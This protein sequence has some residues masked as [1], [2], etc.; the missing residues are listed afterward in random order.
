MSNIWVCGDC[1]SVNP[2]RSGRCYKC[3]APRPP[4]GQEMTAAVATAFEAEPEAPRV[5]KMLDPQRIAAAGFGQPAAPVE[6]TRPEVSKSA[7]AA[8]N[9][10]ARLSTLPA[11]I[12]GIALLIVILGV[13]LVLMRS[14][15][16]STEAILRG[17]VSDP[18][19]DFVGPLG[20][21]YP[22]FGVIAVAG[23]AFWAYRVMTNVPLLGGG[24][25]RFTPAQ[26]LLE[27]VIP[28]WNVLRT[29]GVYREIQTRLSED[30]DAS[31]LLI[32]AWVL[33]NIAA[34]AIVRPIGSTIAGFADSVESALTIITVVNYLSIGLQ[35]L[36]IL[37]IA[38]LVF[39]IEGQQRDRAR[40]LLAGAAAPAQP[41]ADKPTEAAHSAVRGRSV[42][43]LGG[44]R[45]AHQLRDRQ[46]TR[47]PAAERRSQSDP[48]AR[49]RT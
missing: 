49:R 28:G 38:L 33:V 10:Q 23:L 25:P 3:R 41:V 15:L 11:A 32:V 30:G 46:P 35:G 17:E 24:W 26:A 13:R 43:A 2:V 22:L 27:H 45:A 29:P 39:E 7:Q 34:V 5:V 12:V 42:A 19:A 14:S 48:E 37:L 40:M 18:N 1:H 4:E 44:T 47:A 36:A 20:I 16:A 21:L 31:D 9:P 8:I 6:K